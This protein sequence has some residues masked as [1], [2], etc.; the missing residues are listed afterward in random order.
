MSHNCNIKCAWKHIL[1]MMS[2][3]T[4]CSDCKYYVNKYLCIFMYYYIFEMH[5]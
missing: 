1:C 4:K 2:Y 3:N 5:D